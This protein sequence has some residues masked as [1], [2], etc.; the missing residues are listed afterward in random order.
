MKLK[1]G[2]VIRQ[3]GSQY[4]VVATGMLTKT[5]DSALRFNEVGADIFNLL[6]KDTTKKKMI[7]ELKKVYPDFMYQKEFVRSILKKDE[8][9]TAS[10]EN[11]RKI[12][13]TQRKFLRK[14]ANLL[15]DRGPLDSISYTRW[16]RENNKSDIS[17]E[18][19]KILEEE[20][21]EVL[22]SDDVSIIFFIPIEFKLIDDGYRTMD[23][24]QRTEV[25]DIMLDYINKWNLSKK[26]K[27]LRGDVDSRVMYCEGI[28]DG[29]LLRDE[30]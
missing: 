5:F 29:Y 12:L 6:T 1:E 17:E 23:E 21:K 9:N 18:D 20:S 3:L 27:F 26:T 22:Q 25:E 30:K 14:Q 2:L 13:D 11:Q 24:D 4:I 7:K 10:L 28:I 16:L 15:G 19:F 8:V